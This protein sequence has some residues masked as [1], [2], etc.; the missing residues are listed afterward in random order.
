MF[1]QRFIQKCV[2]R[3]ENA[4]DGAVVLKEVGEEAN[5]LL[6]HC[7][8][9]LAEGREVACAFLVERVE[10]VDVQ[11]LAGEF[12]RQPSRARVAKHPPRLHQQRLGFVQVPHSRRRA[13][14][15]VGH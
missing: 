13:Q 6:I 15:P 3:V 2:V 14:L 9:Q 7:A 10:A 4:Q 5:R 8:P 1:R 12:R 11:P